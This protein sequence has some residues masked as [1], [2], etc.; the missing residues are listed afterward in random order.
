MGVVTENWSV[1]STVLLA[2]A[3][4]FLKAPAYRHMP[5]LAGLPDTLEDCFCGPGLQLGQLF[6]WQACDTP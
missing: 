1:G 6:M 4:L 5:F 3:L 2:R